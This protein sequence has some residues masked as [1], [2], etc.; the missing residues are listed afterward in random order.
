MIEDTKN[1]KVLYLTLFRNPIGLILRKTYQ[2][3]LDVTYIYGTFY[4]KTGAVDL[5]I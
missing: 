1:F 3:D 5:Y 2:F 4:G